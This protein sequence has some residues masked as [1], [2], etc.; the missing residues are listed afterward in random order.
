M[1][2]PPPVLDPELIAAFPEAARRAVYE[3]IAWRRDIRHFQP[4]LP[5]D[6]AI[7]E[8]ILGAAHAAPS[9]GF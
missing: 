1:S 6:D 9:V 4:N 5:V 8:R 7:L 3:C 2:I